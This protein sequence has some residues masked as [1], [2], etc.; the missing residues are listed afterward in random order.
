M[1]LP[2]FIPIG[3]VGAV[4]ENGR[5]N[6]E[7]NISNDRV[8]PVRVTPVP[9]IKKVYTNKPNRMEIHNLDN[10]DSIEAQ[11]NP[12]ALTE[13]LKPNWVKQVIPGHSH[14]NFQYAAT[15]AQ[16]FQFDLFFDALELT[17][18]TFKGA[19]PDDIGDAP[20]KLDATVLNARNFLQ[21]L[22]VPK[23]NAKDITASA[24][25][26]CLFFWPNFISLTC[27]VQ[28][29]DFR[30]TK[31]A[32]TGEPLQFTVSITLSEIRDARLTT[33]EVRNVGTIR[34]ASPLDRSFERLL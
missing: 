18:G 27:I 10:G 12:T 1:A 21:S 19:G 15:D 28:S 20:A 22:T 29:M 23:G 13:S 3:A 8:E 33:S 11:F 16:A 14:P 30:H 5:R 32:A 4:F 2:P 9:S 17:G 25:P 24:P 31:F 26:R 6:V 7:S 34:S